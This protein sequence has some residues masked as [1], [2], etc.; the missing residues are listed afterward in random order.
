MPKWVLVADDDPLIRELWVAALGERGY[1][2]LAVSDGNALLDLIHAVVPDLVLLDLRMPEMSGSDFLRALQSSPVLQ[3]IPVLIVSGFLEDEG[4]FD[5]K[6]LNIVGRLP[7]PLALPDL[8]AAV[9]AV[10]TPGP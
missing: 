3:R 9:R 7:K 4:P 10:L 5:A 2:A 6:G 8:V 1:R